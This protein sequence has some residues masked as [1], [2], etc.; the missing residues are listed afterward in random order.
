MILTRHRDILER[1][2]RIQTGYMPREAAGMEV[3]EPYGHS[4][5]WSRRFIGL[6]LFLT[7]VVAGWEGYAEMLRGRVALGDRLRRKL[8]ASDWEVVNETP[9]PLV[10][11]RDDRGARTVDAADIL[12]VCCRRP[13]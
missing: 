13:T 1:T 10:C 11:F 12:R 5:Q 9:L 4:M 6:K 7:L 8:A 2:F 3:I